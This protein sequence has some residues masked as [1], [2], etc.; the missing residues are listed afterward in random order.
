MNHFGLLLTLCISL[1][2]TI[3]GAEAAA[4][5]ESFE[6][7]CAVVDLPTGARDSLHPDNQAVHAI[8]A[9][10]D[11]WKEA[12]R[13][14]D[15]EAVTALVT[16]SAEF[17]SHGAAPIRGRPALAA[18][19]DPFFSNYELLQEFVCD[20]LVV[21]GD[22]AFMRGVERNQLIPRAEG[23]PVTVQQR[24]FSILRRSADGRWRFARGM[25][26]QGSEQ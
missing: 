21:R 10:L 15:A 25:T 26:N 2:T 20:E 1:T 8:Y 17:W 11:Q 18:A 23:D 19:F 24:A 5:Q 3:V 9:L 6:T 13:A 4:A 14:G 22:L 7:R 16:E 12:L